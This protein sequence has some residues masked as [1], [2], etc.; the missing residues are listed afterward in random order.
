[1]KNN[2]SFEIRDPIHGF[3]ILNEWEGDI[4][5]HPVFQGLRRIPQFGM[6]EMV[7]PGAA[8]T[9]FEHSLGVMHV[10]SFVDRA[11]RSWCKYDA[12]ESPVVVR[13]GRFDEGLT[14]LSRGST[15]VCVERDYRRH[16]EHLT[17]REAIRIVK[18]LKPKFTDNE[19]HQAIVELRERK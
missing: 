5:N 11:E 13:P 10:A 14:S 18:Q 16:G 4:V 17:L 9:R 19:I 2:R 8:H 15:V 12:R 1:M 6:T 7:Y 3:V